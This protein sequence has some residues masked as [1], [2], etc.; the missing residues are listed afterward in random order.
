[1]LIVGKNI[2]QM[3]L[4]QAD[5]RP[6]TSKKTKKKDWKKKKEKKKKK[7]VVVKYINYILFE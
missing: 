1:M 4:N 2:M 3:F 6:G 5:V 7:K